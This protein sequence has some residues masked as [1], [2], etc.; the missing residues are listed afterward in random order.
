MLLTEIPVAQSGR[1]V[2]WDVDRTSGL[3]RIPGLPLIAIRRLR[4]NVP[5]LV[6]TNGVPGL[7]QSGFRGVIEFVSPWIV[8]GVFLLC[9]QTSPELGQTIG[10]FWVLREAGKLVGIIF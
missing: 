2:I 1:W 6:T 8:S 4:R 7:I 10:V 3:E 5:C 9:F